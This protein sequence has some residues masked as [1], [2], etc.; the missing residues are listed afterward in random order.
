[1]LVASGIAD[2]NVAGS[3][4]TLFTNAV[5]AT[6]VL[7]SVDVIVA[8]TTL[9]PKV[10]KPVNVGDAIGAFKSNAA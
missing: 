8:A 4:T 10:T 1:M 6:A 5:V 7:L 2:N 9:L 3:L